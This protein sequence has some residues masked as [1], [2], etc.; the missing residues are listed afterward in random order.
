MQPINFRNSIG[1]IVI[2]FL[3]KYKHGTTIATIIIL[4]LNAMNEI[5][6]KLNSKHEFQKYYL[7]LFLIDLVAIEIKRKTMLVIII[8]NFMF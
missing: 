6:L 1:F 4:L 8:K 2:E 7:I 3:V 5:S